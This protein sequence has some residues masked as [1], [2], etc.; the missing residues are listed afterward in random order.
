MLQGLLPGCSVSSPTLLGV[1]AL[2]MLSGAERAGIAWAS[3]CHN[4][5]TLM[6]ARAVSCQMP[7][8]LLLPVLLRLQ[9]RGNC[10]ARFLGFAYNCLPEVAGMYAANNRNAITR[11]EFKPPQGDV[12]ISEFM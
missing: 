7:K 6:C 9:A 8:P 12:D 11:F 2:G 10:P 1:H 5:Q 3:K 4:Q